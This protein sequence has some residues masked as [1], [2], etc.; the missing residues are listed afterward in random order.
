MHGPD[1]ITGVGQQMIAA[2][3]LSADSESEQQKS[4]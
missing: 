4:A 1:M 3:D 2:E